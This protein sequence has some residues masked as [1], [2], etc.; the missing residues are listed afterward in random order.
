MAGP[1]DHRRVDVRRRGGVP[2]RS[3]L[4]LVEAKV[5]PPPRQTTDFEGN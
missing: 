5:K 4:V 1:L 2:R 3:P